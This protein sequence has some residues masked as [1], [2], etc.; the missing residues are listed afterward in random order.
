MI[1]RK[2]NRTWTFSK[3]EVQ[4][5]QS[6]LDIISHHLFWKLAHV[7]SGWNIAMRNMPKVILRIS[8]HI[9]T[10]SNICQ[11]RIDLSY[12]GLFIDYHKIPTLIFLNCTDAD[13]KLL[14]KI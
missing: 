10:I 14:V 13:M 12:Y 8:F 1:L 3:L 5:R 9:D 11:A 4:L 7:F 6:C 2:K